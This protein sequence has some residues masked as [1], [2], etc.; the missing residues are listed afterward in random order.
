MPYLLLYP[1]QVTSLPIRR[2]PNAVP[3]LSIVGFSTKRQPS[4]KLAVKQG[5]IEVMAER[6]AS[7]RK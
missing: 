1:T 3:K 2:R 4:V 5:E 6:E 7:F